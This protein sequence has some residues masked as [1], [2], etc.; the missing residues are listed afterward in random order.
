MTGTWAT[1]WATGDIVTAAE[2]KKAAG[3]IFDTTLGGTAATVDV[4]SI[5]AA[6]AHLLITIYAR[7]DFAGANVN[8]SIRFNGDSGANYDAQLLAGTAA[9]PS[10]AEAFGQTSAVVLNTPAA[11]A[12]ANLFSSAEIFI[13]NYAG[14]TNNKQTVSFDGVKLGTATGNLQVILRSAAWRSNAA[15]NRITLL[16]ASGNFVAGTRVTIYAMGA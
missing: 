15:I 16:P 12:P 11:T 7:G 5:S 8:T 13:P 3:S 1:G 14:S 2:F 6:Y 10:A 4:T 9:T